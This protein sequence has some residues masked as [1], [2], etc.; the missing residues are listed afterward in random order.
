MDF[1]NPSAPLPADAQRDSTLGYMSDQETKYL[2]PL[3]TFTEASSQ[4]R[5]KD[6]SSS[7][8]SRIRRAIGQQVEGLP[9]VAVA[10]T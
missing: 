1:C 7:V 5:L 3:G 2:R 4:A 9:V 8:N 10:L 6:N